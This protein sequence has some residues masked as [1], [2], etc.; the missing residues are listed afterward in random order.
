M[1]IK[2]IR[3]V[4]AIASLLALASPAFG[5]WSGYPVG[6]TPIAVSTTGTT[7]ASVTL[8]AVPGQTTYI[9]GFSIRANAT[10]AIT[11][12]ATVSGTLGGTLNF[13]QYTPATGGTIAMSPVEPTFGP[14]CLPATAANT[15]IVITS[16]GNGG[17]GGGI[18]VT[19]WGFQL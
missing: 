13:V 6:A 18:S 1:M 7:A 4:V 3:N 12:N 15:V 16:A 19:A 5:A 17:G 14:Y 11:G 10:A 2:M 9:C 8:P